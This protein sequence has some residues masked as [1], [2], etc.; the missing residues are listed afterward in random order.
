[1]MGRTP[2][3]A[4]LLRE[5]SHRAGN[6]CAVAIAALRLIADAGFA[7]GVPRA[8]LIAAARARLETSAQLHRL[9]ARP[10]PP[11]ADVGAWL[12]DV[13]AAVT[14]VGPGGSPVVAELDLPELWLDGTLAR[15]LVMIGAE[16]VTNAVKYASEDGKSIRVSA[17]RVEDRVTLTIVDEGSGI[18]SDAA[19]TGTGLGSGIV[20]DLVEI[21]GGHMS[22]ETGVRGTSFVIDMPLERKR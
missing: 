8:R 21:G 19:A 15:R 20:A 16:L 6:D 7:D 10:V 11:A 3:E 13:C 17:R 1:M 18:R 5:V 2:E 4:V 14:S 22:M 12:S 9:L